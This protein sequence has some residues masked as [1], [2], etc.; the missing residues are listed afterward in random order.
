MTA[1]P[2]KGKTDTLAKARKKKKITLVAAA[3][4][5]I[6][7]ILY[8]IL[9]PSEEDKDA[10]QIKSLVMALTEQEDAAAVK[11]PTKLINIVRGKREKP[12]PK[13]ELDK[14]KSTM[15]EL[16]PK[17]KAIVT[18]EVIRSRI[19]RL[20]KATA[21]MSTEEKDKVVQKMVQDIKTK[22]DNMNMASREAAKDQLNSDKGKEETKQA[23]E[24]YYKDMNAEERKM[25]APAVNELIKNINSL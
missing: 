3:G 8:G 21:N 24:V 25:F 20:R 9:R 13:E 1:Q 5:I 16:S 10:D 18:R 22:F 7:L 6:L 15:S 14:I 19:D 2:V 12:I 11:D 17:T 23:F 4:F